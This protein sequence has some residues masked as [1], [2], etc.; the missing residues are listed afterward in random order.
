MLLTILKKADNYR[1]FYHRINTGCKSLK[2]IPS[3]GEKG[4]QFLGN[5]LLTINKFRFL[6]CSQ[7]QKLR[8]HIRQHNQCWLMSLQRKKS[9]LSL[10]IDPLHFLRH[11][12]WS[13]A[14]YRS[15]TICPTPSCLNNTIIY[16]A[17]N[18]QTQKKEKERKIPTP[19]FVVP[20][21]AII[22]HVRV[23]FAGLETVPEVRFTEF[24]QVLSFS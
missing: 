19:E 13:T 1:P 24:V 10:V 7:T 11:L 9:K 17:K 18:C 5:L 20:P 3:N 21:N 4:L 14:S 8:C 22:L 23:K 16:V 6:F 2:P 15:L 12:G